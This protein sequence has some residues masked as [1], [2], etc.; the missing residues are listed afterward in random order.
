MNLTYNFNLGNGTTGSD[1][2]NVIG[3]TNASDGIGAVN[4]SYDSLNRINS[5]YS[6][7]STWGENYKIDAWGNLTNIA[8]YPGKTNSETLNC[9][10]ANTQNQLN[11]C[12]SYDAA[13]NLIQNGTNTYTYDA[14]NR[15]ITAGGFSYIYDGDGN[16][17]EKC[18]EAT[19]AQGI[20]VPGTCASN[21][22][23][24]FYWRFQDGTPQ[25]ESD[26]G[27]NWTA[28]YG[29]I[30]GRITSRVDL[31]ANLNIAHY[32]FQD[33]LHSTNV[34]TDTSGNIEQRSDYYPYGGEF[35]IT[36]G[37]SNH[38]KFTGKERDA[39]SG[40]DNFGARFNSSSIGRWM[41]P[42]AINVT[43][44]RIVSPANTLNKYIYGG[45]NPLKYIDSDGRDITIFYDPGGPAGHIMLAAYNQQNGDFAFLS[46]GP[47]QHGPGELLKPLSGV[48][49]TTEYE[50]PTSVDDLRQNFT[51]VTIQTN[52]EV[53]Q[54]AID[55][56]RNGAGTGNWALLGNNCTSSCVKLLKDIGL[57]SGSNMGLPWTPE[58]FWGNIQAKYGRSSN[59]FSR[60]F[61]NTFGS[62]SFS[63]AHNGED[64]GNPRYG[65]DTFDWLMSM[66]RSAP[67]GN[68]TTTT[69]NCVIDDR[70][71]RVCNTF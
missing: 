57:S 23:G 15:L 70:G 67:Q 25:A 44:E 35:V 63:P 59:P 3:V 8:L 60:F 64:T 49:G 36:A 1:N 34:I 12:Y 47:Q 20:P 32:Y 14:E 43:D 37:D 58:R 11:T 22:T 27:G 45:N 48:P 10:P 54:Q 50:L 52:P 28:S 24:T 42:D 30:R 17:I 6:T 69:T 13:G 33:G 66:F 46:V 9:A 40:L 68:V 62:G 65:M 4:Y 38:Y 31:T 19:N 16:R 41:S 39:E 51:A 26:L 5:A 7:R 29:V 55:A 53:A 61:A 56:I 2:G 21:A 71:N 18:T